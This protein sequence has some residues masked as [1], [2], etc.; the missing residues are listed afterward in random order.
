MMCVFEPP[1][2]WLIDDHEDTVGMYALSA[3][4]F[5]PVTATEMTL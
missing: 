4:G 3:I 1:V 5:H 2:E